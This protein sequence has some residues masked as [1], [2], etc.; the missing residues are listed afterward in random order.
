MR[1]VILTSSQTGTAAHH[2]PYLLKSNKIE[3]VSVIYNEGIVF[4]KKRHYTRKLKKIIKIGFLGALNGIRIRKWFNEDVRAYITIGNLK[5]ICEQAGVPFHYTP[6]I[7][8]IKTQHLFR[9]AKAE[10]G[11]SIGNG[12]IGSNVFNI[13]TY[14]MLNIHHEILPQ[15][16]NAQSIIWQIYNGSKNTGYTIHKIDRSIDTGEILY[17]EKLPIIFE[18][19][20]AKTIAHTSATL[21]KSSAQGL[22]KVLENFQYYFSLAIPQG[23]GKSYT[24]PSFSQYLKIYKQYK[25][26]KKRA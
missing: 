11:I 21:L 19:T 5:N 15:Y 7:N 1:V 26:L 25:I 14:G 17:Q 3:V 16:Q 20:I 8:S 9:E 13:P 23:I 4:N 18:D 6:T 24:T 10:I 22:V 2:L 12:Y